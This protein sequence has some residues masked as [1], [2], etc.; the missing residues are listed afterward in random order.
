MARCSNNNRAN[1]YFQI[2][3]QTDPGG[4]SKWLALPLSQQL[5]MKTTPYIESPTTITPN[6][7]CVICW[8]V[9][10]VNACLSVSVCV[11][12]ASS[13]VH[14]KKKQKVQSSTQSTWKYLLQ[15][16]LFLYPPSWTH[17]CQGTAGLYVHYGN[18]DVLCNTCNSQT[19]RLNHKQKCIFRQV[20]LQFW[21][22]TLSIYLVLFSIHL[23]Q[24]TSRWS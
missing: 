9:L 8:P 22:F 2:M 3:V 15:L 13:T 24:H 11:S 20:L 18:F 5:P 17:H 1:F 19:V 16:L 4:T 23:H 21:P 10:S 6:F 14:K 12:V 7:P